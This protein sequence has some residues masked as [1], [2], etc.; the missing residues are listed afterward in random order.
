MKYWKTEVVK[1]NKRLLSLPNKISEKNKIKRNKNKK[2]QSNAGGDAGGA[3]TKG[4]AGTV[5]ES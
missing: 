2:A 5:K 4:N 1:Q 3:E